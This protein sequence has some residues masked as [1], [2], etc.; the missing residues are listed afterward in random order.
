MWMV[1]LSLYT[2]THTTRKQNMKEKINYKEL[3]RTMTSYIGRVSYTDLKG[4]PDHI[5]DARILDKAEVLLGHR[6]ARKELDGFYPGVYPNWTTFEEWRQMLEDVPEDEPEELISFYF[7]LLRLVIHINLKFPFDITLPPFSFVNG[8]FSIC[9]SEMQDFLAIPNYTRVQMLMIYLLSFQDAEN[10]WLDEVLYARQITALGTEMRECSESQNANK[11]LQRYFVGL[12]MLYAF[13]N[14]IRIG[15]RLGL[16]TLG[17]KVYDVL[18]GM[19]SREFDYRL[20]D[21]TLALMKWVKEKW[22]QNITLV[23]RAS[24][25]E[26]IEKVVEVKRLYSVDLLMPEERWKVL[27]WLFGYEGDVEVPAD[28]IAPEEY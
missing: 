28:Y 7:Y 18:D 5:V 11:H 10:R 2:H 19:M 26:L 4:W 13:A 15:R 22:G 1:P 21:T 9:N 6:N 3:V 25:N 14:H 17:L 12:D 8:S 23:D 16:D 20:V 27:F 24:I